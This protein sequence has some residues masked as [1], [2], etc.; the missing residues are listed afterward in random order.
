MK[1]RDPYAF[2]GHRPMT[3]E[4]MAEITNHV[5]EEYVDLDRTN[6][7]TKQELC[8]V[9]LRQGYELDKRRFREATQRNSRKINRLLAKL[10]SRPA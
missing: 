1:R 6:F 4:R 3:P 7:A 10:R 9:I 2:D 5:S 8:E